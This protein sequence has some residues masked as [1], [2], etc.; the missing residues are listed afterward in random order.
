MPIVA[1]SIVRSLTGMV[2]DPV[3][4]AADMVDGIVGT[5]TSLRDGGNREC[6]N[7]G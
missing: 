2:R 3:M 1:C 6:G 7:C 5:V 4:L